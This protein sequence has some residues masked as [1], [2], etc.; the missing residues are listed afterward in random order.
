MI[1]YED[2]LAAV[3]KSVATLKPVQVETEAA[4]GLVLARPV[5]AGLRMPR[6]DQSAMDGIAVRVE[7]VTGASEDNPVTLRLIDEIPAG[8]ARRPALREGT[9]IKVF[10]GSGVPNNTGGIVIVEDCRFDGDQVEV[11]ASAHPGGH[12]RR[13]GEE[14]RRGDLIAAEGTRLTPPVVGLLTLFGV[15]RVRVFPAPRVGV[16]TMGDELAAPGT[17]LGAAQIYDSNGPALRAALRAM[18][19]ETIH[20]WRVGD[21]P[22]ELMRAF[23]ESIRKCDVV[24]SCGGA[25]VGDHDHVAE[26]RAHVR[27]EDLFTRVAIKPGKPNVFGL[28]PK[29]VPVFS[30]PGNPVSALVSFRQIV[31]PG[32]MKMMGQALEQETEVAVATVGRARKPGRLEWL[33]GKLAHVNGRREVSAVDAQGSHMLT[34]L[35]N[36]DVLMEIPPD[37][38]GIEAGDELVVRRL[39]WFG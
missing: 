13:A 1:S 10:T 35:A 26:A 36:A 32:L 38:E 18:G 34:G 27:I 23:R 20:S 21:Q 29:G 37:S 7:D 12:I 22:T 19:I 16:I 33:R 2:A 4:L 24:I 39:G 14:V 30:L 3:L 31:R 6:H 9:A 25:S 15:D 28:A 11:C 17:R 8:S 5:K